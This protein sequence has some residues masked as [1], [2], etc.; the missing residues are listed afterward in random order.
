[1]MVS[2]SSTP[3][4][5]QLMTTLATR[6][7]SGGRFAT[8]LQLHQPV[9]ASPLAFPVKAQYCP[10]CGLDVFTN[11]EA[12]VRLYQAAPDPLD[13]LVLVHCAC[14]QTQALPAYLFE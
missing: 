10:G 9:S 14:G 2:P 13:A 8:Q 11:P 6:L 1:M 4:L 7:A 12:E 3:T 5:Q